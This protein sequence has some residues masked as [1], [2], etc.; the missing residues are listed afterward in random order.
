MTLQ[1]LPL[2]EEISSQVRG[3]PPLGRAGGSALPLAAGPGRGGGCGTGLV[4]PLGGLFELL[5]L[6]AGLSL[7]HPTVN[8]E[9][10]TTKM[11]KRMEKRVFF[12]TVAPGRVLFPPDRRRARENF[13]DEHSTARQKDL[14]SLL[15]GGR[16]LA[17]LEVQY[18]KPPCP[19]AE[20][21]T[22]FLGT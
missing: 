12:M 5:A 22:F 17:G 10:T 13:S 1:G 7:P 11:E 9:D 2:I 3:P 19:G 20:I 8:R 16:V 21:R 15:G 14:Q 6:N 4:A 18:G